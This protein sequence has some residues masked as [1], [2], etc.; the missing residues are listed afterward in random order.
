MKK[1]KVQY[2][3]PKKEKPNYVIMPLYSGPVK[4]G[5]I[6][7]TTEENA[8]RLE[9]HKNWVSPYIPEKK[10]TKKGKK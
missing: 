10:K 8:K 1:V 2:V 6:V 7:E 5:D 3:G 4:H 9:K